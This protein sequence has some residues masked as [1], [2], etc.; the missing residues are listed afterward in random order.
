MA[1]VPSLWDMTVADLAPRDI[2]F[3]KG[4]AEMNFF[5]A[6]FGGEKGLATPPSAARSR[7]PTTQTPR[8]GHTAC[9]TETQAPGC[10]STS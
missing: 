3:D 9:V 7:L 10:S 1:S 2:P 6:S 5:G 8:H 4:A